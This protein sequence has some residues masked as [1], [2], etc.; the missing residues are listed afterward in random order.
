MVQKEHFTYFGS[1]YIDFKLT[2]FLIIKK[3]L[4]LLTLGRVM[5]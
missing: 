2:E 4:K 3:I 5:D 1:G